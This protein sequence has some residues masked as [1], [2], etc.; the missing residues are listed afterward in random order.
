VGSYLLLIAHEH[1]YVFRKLGEKERPT[2]SLCYSCISGEWKDF[3]V[4]M[5][6][7]TI[8]KMKISSYRFLE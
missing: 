2:K 4:R 1:L 5:A 3:K 7:K 6:M 8:N